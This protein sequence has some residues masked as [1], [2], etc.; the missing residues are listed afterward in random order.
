MLLSTFG[1]LLAPAARMRVVSFRI[2]IAAAVRPIPH[3]SSEKQ[4]GANT[5]VQ[6]T[7]AGYG[8]SP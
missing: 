5:T 3:L 6:N 1:N 4:V 2:T 7:C 8:N